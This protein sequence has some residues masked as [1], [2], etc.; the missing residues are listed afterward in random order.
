ML[1]RIL[2]NL[3]YKQSRNIHLYK[4]LDGSFCVEIVYD[5]ILCCFYGSFVCIHK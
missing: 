5:E 1:E 2:L 4:D 3:I